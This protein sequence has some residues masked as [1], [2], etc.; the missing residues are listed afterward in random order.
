M[1]FTQL[2]FGLIGL[3]YLVNALPGAE[4]TTSFTIEVVEATYV[5]AEVIEAFKNAIPQGSPS[6]TSALNVKAPPTPYSQ[7]SVPST[8]HEP[9]IGFL[10]WR[11]LDKERCSFSTQ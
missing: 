9:F 8:A 11:P 7:A 6:N 5:P 10:N 3:V 4:S 2:F 1:K